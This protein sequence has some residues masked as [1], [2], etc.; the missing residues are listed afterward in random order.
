MNPRS[1][2]QKIYGYT[3]TPLWEMCRY[4]RFMVE[5]DAGR[6]SVGRRERSN[7]A[8]NHSSRQDLVQ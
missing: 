7:A 8:S 2:V 1:K 6:R 5:L 4:I 3:D